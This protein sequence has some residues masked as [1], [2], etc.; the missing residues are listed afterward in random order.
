[1]AGD[2]QRAVEDMDGLRDT[3]QLQSAL[4]GDF[5][6]IVYYGEEHQRSGDQ[7][8]AAAVGCRR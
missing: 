1:M 4:Q 7:L 8:D 3:A 6:F 5:E 2:W